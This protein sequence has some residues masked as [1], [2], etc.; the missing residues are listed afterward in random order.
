MAGIPSIAT[1]QADMVQYG[2]RVPFSFDF[3][4]GNW[5]SPF[6]AHSAWTMNLNSP[7]AFPTKDGAPRICT[8]ATVGGLAVQAPRSGADLYVAGIDVTAASTSAA[9]TL[10]LYDRICD[11]QATE[12]AAPFAS[13][14]LDATSKILTGESCLCLTEISGTTSTSLYSIQY[15]YTNQ[16]NA[17]KTAT[18]S[19][20][21][22]TGNAALIAQLQSYT[23][24]SQNYTPTYSPL[25]AG[26]Q[27]MRTLT[28][29]SLPSGSV[30][31]PG[32]IVY[33]LIRVV[34]TIPVPV[35]GLPQSWDYLTRKGGTPFRLRSDPC[36]SF[37]ILPSST[38]PDGLFSGFVNLLS[39][40]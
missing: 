15:N 27:G 1:G 16:N 21:T 2:Q 18:F 23:D 32:A 4:T 11:I 37:L 25:G 14:A 31:T 33:S 35:T 20:F 6:A 17:A 29:I 34:E 40:P 3:T 39:A 12:G 5:G 30:V 9:M 10:V 22:T 38:A 13:G 7:G 26:D 28:S 36:L 24:G 8:N 19:P